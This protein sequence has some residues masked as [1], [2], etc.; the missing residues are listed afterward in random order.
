MNILNTLYKKIGKKVAKDIEDI[1]D[2][3]NIE[4]TKDTKDTE[5]V[6]HSNNFIFN[7]PSNN[8]ENWTTFKLPI[9]YQKKIRKIDQHIIYDLELKNDTERDISSLYL[10]VYNPQTYFGQ[11]IIN[12]WS[13][14]YTYN[15]SF[16][17][18]S[19]KLI[20][21][22]KNNVSFN[23]NNNDNDDEDG[24][25]D[26]EIFNIFK[27]TKCDTEFISR[28]QY[29]SFSWF[30][31]LNYNKDI[32]S[33]L[34]LYNLS[35]PL[36][37]LITPI[38]CLIL[39]FFIIKLQGHTITLELYM[40]YLKYT[41]GK[42]VL[43]KLIN[44]FKGAIFEQKVYIIISFIFYIYQLYQNIISCY[45]FYINIKTIHTILFK[46]RD[47]IQSSINSMNNFYKYSKIYKSY[48][49]FNNDLNHNIN[50][51]S[52]Y[53]KQLSQ[54]TDYKISKEKLL[55]IGHLMKCFYVLHDN[56]KLSDA[57]RYSFGFNGYID[58]LIGLKR[59][60]K[61]KYIN[62]CKFNSKKC[63]FKDAYFPSLMYDKPTKNSY[64]LNNHLII[65][66]P[67]AAGK[68]TILKS[69]LFNI[70][71]S[72]QIGCGFYTKATI[73]IYNY[74]HCYINIPDTSGRDSL[75]QAEA[76]RCKEILQKINKS[77]TKNHFCVFDELYSGTN[78]YEAIG[79]AYSFLKYLNTY[80][81]INFILTTHY[82]DLC[83]K[84]DSDKLINNCHMKIQIDTSN[85][86]EYTYKL[87]NGISN[88][89]GATKVLKD[90]E[91][92]EEIL[93]NMKNIVNTLKL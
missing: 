56:T 67:N 14:Y 10:Y 55:N 41:L 79:S 90:L 89:R 30:K 15:K 7:D 49:G 4:D 64:K 76:R 17:N 77:K 75:F 85:N 20:K 48:I 53:Y 63:E 83:N 19:K 88:F 78:P 22:F 72:H 21:N 42:H 51:L 11:K 37:S 3:E 25:G 58:N 43:G 91:Y 26:E 8:D 57:L 28:Y 69:T 93:S 2:M 24:D 39:P 60:M 87:E 23:N 65:T 40:N 46:I 50:I 29:I 9:E 86:F 36:F 5:D 81:N 35:L 70:I 61:N 1:E 92:P 6:K 62:F 84:F 12:K 16:L 71:L 73:K 31:E 66:G 52:N 27:D 68:T 32:L 74:I 13:N 34:S 33:V 54:I 38:I 82:T 45:N 44:N 47:Y 80:D 59:N 18:D